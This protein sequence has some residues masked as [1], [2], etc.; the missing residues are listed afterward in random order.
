MLFG[1]KRFH[2]K[3]RRVP[4]HPLQAQQALRGLHNFVQNDLKHPVHREDIDN[5]IMDNKSVT[6]C[7]KTEAACVTGQHHLLFCLPFETYN[8]RI[9]VIMR[10][11]FH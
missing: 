8:K 10:V 5:C 7:N 6:T 11:S 4:R 3:L 9:A 1:P 2:Q